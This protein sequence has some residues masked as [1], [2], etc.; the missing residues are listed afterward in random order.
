MKASDR[1]AKMKRIIVPLMI[2]GCVLFV[3]GLYI[4]TL[5]FGSCPANTAQFIYDCV[6]VFRGTSIPITPTGRAVSFIGAVIL[7]L[8]VPVFVWGSSWW[9]KHGM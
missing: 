7:V 3:V 9:S 5:D 6:H 4:T 1:E 2:L 8:T